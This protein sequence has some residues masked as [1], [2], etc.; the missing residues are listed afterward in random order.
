VASTLKFLG[1]LALIPVLAYTGITALNLAGI[2]GAS[3]DTACQHAHAKNACAATVSGELV[4]LSGDDFANG[5]DIEK[6]ALRTS[7]GNTVEVDVSGWSG[8]DR[9]IGRHVQLKGHRE[10]TVFVAL[11]GASTSGTTTSLSTVA[12]GIRSTAVVLLNFTNDSTQPWT[13]AT[14]SNLM[15]GGTASV[16]AF[17]L[18]ESHGATGFSGNVFGWVTVPYDNTGC[19]FG[20]W[21]K[22]A[23]QKAGV[24]TTKY[25]N[26]VYVWPKTTSC[27]WAGLATIGG[28][29]AWINGSMTI[30][31]VSHEL[32]HN[33]GVH[34]A[35]ALKCT[36]NGTPVPWSSTCTTYEY[37]DPFSVMGVAS[38]TARHHHNLQ[39]GQFGWVP[40]LIDITA[41]GSYTISPA[42]L[43]AQPRMF[44]I[45]RGD[46]TFLYLEFRRPY[47]SFDAYS[48]ADPVVNGVTIRVAPDKPTRSQSFLLDMV[49]STTSF[50]DAPLAVG[51]T[52]TD[53]LTKI[54]ITTT[55]ASSSMATI[56]VTRPGTTVTDVQPPMV[57]GSLMAV[58]T[59]SSTVALSWVASSDNVGVTGY[60]VFRNGTLLATPTATSYADSGLAPATA[61]GYTVV[62]FDAAANTSLAATASA[63]TQPPATTLPPTTTTTLPPTTTT[64][65]PPSTTLPPPTTTVA[66]PPTSTTLPP[67]DTTPPSAPDS[68][69]GTATGPSS[70]TLSWSASADDRGVTGYN[71][72]RDGVLIATINAT[73]FTDSG[74]APSTTYTYS[75]VAFDAAGNVGPAASGSVATAAPAPQLPAPTGLT[76]TRGKGRNVAVSWSAVPG[77]ASYRLYRDGTLV[78]NV[79][80]TAFAESL[81]G[82]FSSATYTVSAL[83]GAGVEGLVSPP[84]VLSMG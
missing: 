50:A 13:T 26:V 42:A 14:V 16:N 38:H 84:F 27:G 62:A 80:A 2:A 57:P 40:E 41:S 25:T 6:H 19:R 33:L 5:R 67:R 18:E 77:A 54:A 28:N 20:D 82:K 17:Y 83:D 10:G 58:A 52:F 56:Q 70:I 24:D 53:P 9:N 73:T 31:V 21:A 69:M 15:F 55:S 37:G 61:Y 60:R 4:A 1:R 64:L 46:G 49:P 30:P 11:D 39:L 68:L 48:S 74:L 3:T 45:S 44:R 72:S 43:T 34:H 65:P 76:A 78:A 81:P 32:G 59:G 36:L 47:G 12:A 79:P 23:Q 71:L 7:D 22:A 35:S 51:A 8:A 75:V 29:Q 63:T 66:P